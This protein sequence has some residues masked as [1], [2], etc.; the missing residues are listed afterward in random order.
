MKLY[1]LPGMV[2]ASGSYESATS[3]APRPLKPLRLPSY[4]LFPNAHL[5]TNA[6]AIE[7]RTLDSIRWERP[8]NKAGALRLE[9]GRSG[10]TAQV[11]ALGLRTLVVGRDGTA[12]DRSDWPLSRTFRSGD[13]ENLLVADNRTRQY[14]AATE[15]ERQRLARMAW[16]ERTTV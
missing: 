4:P 9:S 11:D 13:Q 7:R 16:G 2:A 10:L 6:M 12:F 5:R 3:A 8:R 14:E 15:P 1:G